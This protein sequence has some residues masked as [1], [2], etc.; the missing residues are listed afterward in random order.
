MERSGADAETHE[1]I[2]SSRAPISIHLRKVPGVIPGC[3]EQPKKK[4]GPKAVAPGLERGEHDL[5]AQFG[6]GAVIVAYIF[7]LG[8]A[9]LANRPNR[10]RP[11]GPAP[12]QDAPASALGIV[13]R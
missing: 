5:V 4:R 8:Q 1:M 10:Q 3:W 2:A 9:G 13:L 12:A 7:V 11:S 6:I